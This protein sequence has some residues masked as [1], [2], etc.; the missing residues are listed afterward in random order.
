MLLS[1]ILR[2]R[3]CFLTAS[4]ELPPTQPLQIL[5]RVEQKQPISSKLYLQRIPARR[6]LRL[7]LVIFA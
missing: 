7:V 6:H 1:G 4:R 3:A 2:S 5:R